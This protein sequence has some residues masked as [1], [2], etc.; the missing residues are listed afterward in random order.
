MVL[1]LTANSWLEKYCL[2]LRSK[3]LSL[4]A[5]VCVP[6][7]RAKF[8][9]KTKSTACHIHSGDS[10]SFCREHPVMLKY[11]GRTNYICTV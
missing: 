2:L 4:T 9:K 10:F 3:D 7:I 6:Y 5:Q 8:S 1:E 11:I